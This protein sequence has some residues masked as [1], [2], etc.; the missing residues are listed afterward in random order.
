M[1]DVVGLNDPGAVTNPNAIRSGL[2]LADSYV[3]PT[4]VAEAEVKPRPR[5]R[6]L[7]VVDLV[8]LWAVGIAAVT[9]V[10]RVAPDRPLG[11]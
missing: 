1:A 9:L 3:P 5:L 4:P 8:A 11:V 7:R 6:L 2:E 10:L